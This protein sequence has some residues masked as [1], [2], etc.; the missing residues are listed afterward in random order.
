MAAE[1]DL[2][3]TKHLKVSIAT[4]A[5]EIPTI[6]S[7]LDNTGEWRTLNL[8]SMPSDQWTRLIGHLIARGLKIS[9][10]NTENKGNT[11][12]KKK[13][14]AT[15]LKEIQDGTF[16]PG[17]GGGGA[18]QTPEIKGWIEWLGLI[19]HKE[20]GAAVN[21]NTLARAQMRLCRQDMI[22]GGAVKPTDQEVEVSLAEWIEWKQEDDEGLAK[23]I[24]RQQ[25]K[26]KG[27][28]PIQP[29]AFKPKG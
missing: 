18:R 28:S 13:A 21:S 15:R 8:A 6:V 17:Q 12:E 5:V 26:A 10:D 27:T 29:K 9:V 1:L 3:G 16:Q 23:A 24:R 22:A 25:E 19:G 4:T 20:N 14:G 11:E 7:I 2:E